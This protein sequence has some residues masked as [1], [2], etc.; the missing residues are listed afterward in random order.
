M[1]DHLSLT[2]YMY[3]CKTLNLISIIISLH[4]ST[5]QHAMYI[6]IQNKQK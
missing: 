2:K 1:I 3:T 6:I 5:N 4:K